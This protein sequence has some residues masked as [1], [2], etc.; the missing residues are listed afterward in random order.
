MAQ[1]SSCMIFVLCRVSLNFGP[2]A[3]GINDEA[4]T[5][6]WLVWTTRQLRCDWTKCGFLCRNIC[7]WVPSI[8]P[9]ISISEL[10]PSKDFPSRSRESAS[11]PHRLVHSGGSEADWETK[12]LRNFRLHPFQPLEWEY[13]P[14]LRY[15]IGGKVF[16]G[17]HFH[18]RYFNE[19]KRTTQNSVAAANSCCEVFFLQKLK[20]AISD[21]FL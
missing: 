8:F 15:N 17:E 21:L 12:K 5:V 9:F 3:A 1:N 19:K 18:M 2:Y 4:V 7:E 13:E 16:Y 6:S 11:F 20:F 10:Q 14:Q